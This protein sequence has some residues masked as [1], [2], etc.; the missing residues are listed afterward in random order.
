MLV[1]SESYILR[2]WARENRYSI[3]LYHKPEMKHMAYLAHTQP[4]QYLTMHD[5]APMSHI[6]EK[7]PKLIRV[8]HIQKWSWNTIWGIELQE[9]SKCIEPHSYEKGSTF[10]SERM[11]PYISTL[12]F[13]ANKSWALHTC[14]TY[15]IYKK[16]EFI[17]RVKITK[18]VRTRKCLRKKESIVL[19]HGILTWSL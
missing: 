5:V 7:V 10:W 11:V 6:W 4:R 14:F 13:T 16:L 12:M 2:R 1:V 18:K 3:N 9:V 15:I 19:R 8:F 17:V